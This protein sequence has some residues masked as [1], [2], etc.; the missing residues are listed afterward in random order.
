[1][2]SEKTQWVENKFNITTIIFSTSADM[3]EALKFW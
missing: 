3:D 1:M 2:N